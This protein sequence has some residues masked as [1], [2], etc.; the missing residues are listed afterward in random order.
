MFNWKKRGRIFIPQ[1]VT[2]RDWLKSF[3]QAPAVLK[4]DDFIRVYF[5]CRPGP[6]ENGQY[7]SYSAYLDLDKKDLFKILRIAKEPIFKL[8]ER[9]CFDE[10]G[11]YPTSVI[12]KDGNVWAYYAGW[13]RCE[14][15]PFNVAIGAGISKNDGETFEKI[16]SG[17]PILSYT[18]DEPFVM[19][20]P[21]IR[22]FN[23]TYYLFYIAGRNWIENN[24]KPEPV[25]KIRMAH[26]KDGINWI[27]VNKDLIESR[28]E[29][30]EAQAS[31][32]VFFSN[33]KY[34]MF[35]CYRYGLNYRGKENGYRIG[36]ASSEDLI[37]WKRDDSKAGIDVSNEGWDS[38]MI[39]YP[40]VFELDG[41]VYM[42]YLG[43]AVGKEGFGLAELEGELK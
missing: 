22:Y 15:V 6:D 16:G 17:G 12:R 29:E 20:G 27:K 9:G 21:K 25:Y 8:G 23:D 19:S 10:F 26:S 32:D 35:F 38:E 37:N 28:I 39:S 18:P 33:G 34:H 24:G 36:Y 40:H 31:P 43:N 14:S 5:S 30:N 4:F 7:V 11:T 41:K 13:T 3:A 2:D 42:M 1:E